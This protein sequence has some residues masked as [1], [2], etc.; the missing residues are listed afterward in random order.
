MTEIVAKKTWAERCAEFVARRDEWMQSKLPWWKDCM[1]ILKDKCITPGD[2]YLGEE[3]TG[4]WIHQAWHK[5]SK[6]PVIPAGTSKEK[7]EQIKARRKD[8]LER[9]KIEGISS[10]EIATQLAQSI[11]LD[12]MDTEDLIIETFRNLKKRE[13]NAEFTGEQKDEK[14]HEKQAGR[15]AQLECG[16]SMFAKMK[17]ADV[18]QCLK[19]LS[20]MVDEDGRSLLGSSGEGT[21]R[22][23]WID[24]LYANGKLE[25]GKAKYR[26]ADGHRGCFINGIAVHE[27]VY[28]YAQHVM[29][30]G[31]S[32]SEAVRLFNE[33]RSA[34]R[35]LNELR[36]GGAVKEIDVAP[37]AATGTDNV[38]F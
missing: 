25:L 33:Q 5:Y 31:A 1:A 27:L 20:V 26:N 37:I 9:A 15:E 16:E 17:D 14:I 21:R 24:R 11:G 10:E 22:V 23:D 2:R 35:A 8:A 32:F 28:K 3:F 4:S 38:P 13:M 19:K 7:E 6:T 12:T 18:K 30:G 34:Q 36:N 29:K